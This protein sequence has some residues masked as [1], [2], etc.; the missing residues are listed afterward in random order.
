MC[1]ACHSGIAAGSAAPA[2]AL[3]TQARTPA[4][5]LFRYPGRPAE[6]PAHRLAPAPD[7][8]RETTRVAANTEDGGKWG[9]GAEPTW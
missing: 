5:H 6:S 7:R 8:H 9:L 2:R 3:Q 1:R 4:Q